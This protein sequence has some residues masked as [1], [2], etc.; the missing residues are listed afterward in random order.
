MS[1]AADEAPSAYQVGRLE[2]SGARLTQS[3]LPYDLLNFRRLVT[4]CF[5]DQMHLLAAGE[6]RY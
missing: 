4:A 2:G 3:R 1:M 5:V 6:A